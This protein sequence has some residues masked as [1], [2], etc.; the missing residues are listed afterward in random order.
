M[1]VFVNHLISYLDRAGQKEREKKRLHQL[2][3]GPGEAQHT[4]SSLCLQSKQRQAQGA[5]GTKHPAC[6]R[7]RRALVALA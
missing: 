4:P 7:A 5:V 3:D 2:Y 6:S 1:Y